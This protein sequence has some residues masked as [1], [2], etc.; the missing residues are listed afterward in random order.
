MADPSIKA[1]QNPSE[2]NVFTFEVLNLPALTPTTNEPL[3]FY[4]FFWDFGDGYFSSEPQ[5]THT[6]PATDA[7][8]TSK[9]R[10]RKANQAVSGGIDPMAHSIAVVKMGGGDY[11][12]QP[13]YST[14][15]SADGRVGIKVIYPP[16][17]GE[18]ICC[19]V[20]YH[21]LSADPVSSGSINLKYNQVSAGDPI[22][23]F[24]EAST[25]HNESIVD[26]ELPSGNSYE[27]E[28]KVEFSGLTVGDYRNV[29]LIF[30]VSAELSSGIN[31]AQ[32]EFSITDSSGNPKGV[33]ILNLPI[34]TNHSP[35]EAVISEG[36][37]VTV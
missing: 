7:N 33:S 30:D 11:I 5:P 22:F 35:M 16:V 37:P 6:Y 23:T 1:T 20:S 27:R 2:N 13:D 28:L 18:H 32:L 8:Y 15:L 31:S 17:R 14:L 26:D 12:S 19:L 24:I 10:V 36:S 21:N 34:V 29:C 9:V 4:E 25:F 3:P